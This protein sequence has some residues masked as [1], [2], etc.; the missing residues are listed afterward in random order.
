MARFKDIMFMSRVQ[1][2]RHEPDAGVALISIR[3]P[4]TARPN[5][6]GTWD[7][8]LPVAFHDIDPAHGH[9]DDAIPFDASMADEIIDF[10]EA[11]PDGVRVLA[12]HCH[13]GVSRSAGVAF[14]AAE[15]FGCETAFPFS[16][17]LYNRHVRAVLTHRYRERA[18]RA[19]PDPAG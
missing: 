1:A 11:L 3:D 6:A 19:G 10:I 9:D 15:T 8:V 2:E 12:V 5:L 13:A 17:E 14:F 4:G 7:A 18:Y 16:Y